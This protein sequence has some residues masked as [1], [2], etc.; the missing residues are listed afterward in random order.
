MSIIV[1]CPSRGNPGAAR[2]AFESFAD[3]KM[4]N[5][6][7]F[8]TVVDETDPQRVEYTDSPRLVVPAAS[9]GNMNLALNYAAKI[10]ASEADILGFVG[11]DHR[12]RTQGWDRVISQILGGSGGGYL[13]AD[14]LAQR[15]QLPTQVF[16]TSAIVRALGWFGLPDARHLYLDNTWKLLGEAAD[17]L[18][19]VP[20]LV[21]EHM[22]PAYGKG[23]WDE[24]HVRVNSQD[25]YDHDRQVYEAWLASD[26]ESDVERVRSALTLA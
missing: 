8:V 15:E 11:D 1:L 20:D 25:N 16:V 22:H 4:L 23:D 17:C 18:Y 12:F 26:F 13:Y 24:N 3:T 21:I 14:D 6:S 10:Y 2:A 5:S 9:C 19:Y 7:I